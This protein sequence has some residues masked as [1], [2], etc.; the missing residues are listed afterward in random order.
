MLNTDTIILSALVLATACTTM[1][2][3]DTS[4][5]SVVRTTTQTTETTQTVAPSHKLSRKER[6]QLAMSLSGAVSNKSEWGTTP[7]VETTP[8]KK[9]EHNY[10]GDPQPFYCGY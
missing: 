5:V 8:P 10:F 6:K 7:L 1:A 9:W 2:Y 3:A 4:D